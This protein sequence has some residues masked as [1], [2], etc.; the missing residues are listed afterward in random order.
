MNV[1]GFNSRCR[2]VKQHLSIM[3]PLNTLSHF[4]AVRNV[5]GWY[6][7][8][9]F[10]LSSLELQRKLPVIPHLPYRP[11]SGTLP[12]FTRLSLELIVKIWKNATECNAM[13]PRAAIQDHSLRISPAWFSKESWFKLWAGSLQEIVFFI[14]V[15]KQAIRS[16]CSEFMI[17]FLEHGRREHFLVHERAL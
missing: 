17:M 9:L 2:A 1:N 10:S 16:D 5:C 4:I 8:F 13:A 7:L 11:H 14:L 3:T 15:L 12:L 6:G